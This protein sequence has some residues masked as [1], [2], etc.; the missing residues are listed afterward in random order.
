MFIA[1]KDGLMHSIHSKAFDPA[2]ALAATRHVLQGS[3]P[4]HY[5]TIRVRSNGKL[6]RLHHTYR[7]L[8]HSAS[9]ACS[10]LTDSS[11]FSLAR[12]REGGPFVKTD[13]ITCKR[14]AGEDTN[15]ADNLPLWLSTLRD[16]IANLLMMGWRSTRATRSHPENFRNP[17]I[18]MPVNSFEIIFWKL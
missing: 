13:I 3:S 18:E 8:Q 4:E 10:L 11:D 1:W 2:A 15:R 9:Q 14:E 7:S 17:R 16:T 5:T 12:R 6:T